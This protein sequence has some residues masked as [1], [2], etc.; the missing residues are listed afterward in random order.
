MPRCPAPHPALSSA[1]TATRRAPCTPRPRR[2]PRSSRPSSSPRP[3]R[4]HPPLP[5]PTATARPSSTWARTESGRVRCRT[6]GPCTAGK[7]RPLV[8]R[9]LPRLGSRADSLHRSQPS[10]TPLLP[11]ETCASRRLG[12]S[13]RR[14]A[15]CRTSRTISPGTSRRAS[16]SARPRSLA[17]TLR[18]APRTA[19]RCALP[20]LRLVEPPAGAKKGGK[21]PVHVYTQC[22]ESL[23]S[24]ARRPSLTLA[25]LPC[26]GGGALVPARASSSSSS[27]RPDC[28]TRFPPCRHAE[29]AVAQQRLLRLGRPGQRFHRRQRKLP[30]RPVRPL[31]L[32]HE[33]S[34]SDG[35]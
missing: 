14:T 26:S 18:R 15:P 31:S 3:L 28:L 33:G 20:A 35:R 12:P 30:S 19:S 21:L 17:S 4:P 1:C 25:S 2:S 6:T 10:P 34:S 11:S 8:S 32:F 9:F 24:R 29:L 27:S 22:V 7:V 23:F 5:T 16:S 13:R